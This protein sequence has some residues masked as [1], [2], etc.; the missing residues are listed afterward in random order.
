MCLS[1]CELFEFNSN[2]LPKGT[3]ITLQLRERKEPKNVKDF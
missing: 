2:Y 3:Q 1:I